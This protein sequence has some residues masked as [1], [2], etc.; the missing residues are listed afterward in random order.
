MRL[1]GRRPILDV[2]RAHLRKGSVQGVR[3][4]QHGTHG[5]GKILQASANHVQVLLL[6]DANAAGLFCDSA[7]T[8]PAI[9]R[10]KMEEK[11]ANAAELPHSP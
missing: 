10:E 7:S 4:L 6:G 3:G 8:E 5:F 1:T 9:L 11:N 2:L